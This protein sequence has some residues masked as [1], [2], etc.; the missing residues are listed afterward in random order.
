[1]TEYQLKIMQIVD[2]ARCRI[3]RQF[4]QTL[5]SDRSIRTNGGSDLYYYT[6]LNSYANYRTCYYKLDG[7]NYKVYPGEWVVT[8]KELC[9]WFRTRFHWQAIEILENLQKKHL[10]TYI[11]LYRGSVVKY[12][13]TNWAD[14][15]TVLDYNCP[16]EKESGFFFMSIS[17]AHELITSE[18]CSEMDIVLDLW[19]STIY[20]DS[21]VQGSDVGPVVYFRNGTGSPLSNYSELSKRWGISRST[22][23][24]ILKRLETM[25]YIQLISFPGRKGSVI[26]LQNYLSTMFQISD[27]LIDKEEVA[28][29]LNINITLPVDGIHENALPAQEHEV[30]VP[31]DLASVSKQHIEIIL[32]KMAK[33]LDSQG[34][35][36][37]RCPKS[38]YKLFP[39]SD[40]CLGNSLPPLYKTEEIRFG[41]TVLCSNDK[42]IRTFELTLSPLECS[43]ERR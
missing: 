28:M 11:S 16:C 36:C 33:V 42:P 37:F 20:N 7:H 2:F 3:Y 41:M 31:E 35:S 21:Q 30:S 1:M 23:G 38:K 43:P 26:Y 10:I 19:M 5:I 4:V 18:R 22:V 25:K 24:R 32:Q 39:L 17:S 8:I 15:N 27:I 14:N 29:V 13:V 12:K 6:V 34:L 40:D 9:K